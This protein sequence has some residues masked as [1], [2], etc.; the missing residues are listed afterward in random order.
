MSPNISSGITSF[1]FCVP[2]SQPITA[3][4]SNEIQRP[5]PPSFRVLG[6]GFN[7]TPTSPSPAPTNLSTLPTTL[8]YL[9]KSFLIS[10]ES[11]Q[12]ILTSH[13]LCTDVQTYY[14]SGLRSTVAHQCAS[15]IAS[16]RYLVN[17]RAPFVPMGQEGEWMFQRCMSLKVSDE[18]ETDYGSLAIAAFTKRRKTVRYVHHFKDLTTGVALGLGGR[19]MPPL[20]FDQLLANILACAKTNSD[21]QMGAMIQGLAMAL[22][23]NAMPPEVR[24]RLTEK[25]LASFAHCS[26]QQLRSMICGLCR[27]LRGVNMKPAHRDG[28]LEQLLQAGEASDE[29][30]AISLLDGLFNG[31]GV[32]KMNRAGLDAVLAKYVHFYTDLSSVNPCWEGINNLCILVGHCGMPPGM[33]D[34]ILGAILSTCKTSSTTQLGTM[35]GIMWRRL[36]GLLPDDSERTLNNLAGMIRQ[37]LNAHATLSPH[38]LG[39]LLCHMENALRDRDQI[40]QEIILTHQ[41]VLVKCILESGRVPETIAALQLTEHGQA[42]VDRLRP[43]RVN[44]TI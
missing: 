38:Q 7:K 23:G 36:G 1:S 10:K 33:R 21:R 44:T 13:R 31:M 15:P 32:W 19:L 29:L 22:G 17:R 5:Q 16:F 35:A 27:A 3:V 43:E 9:I 30:P 40:D 41:N 12:L 14:K 26:E 6:C 24:H 42:V 18:N 20:Y 2:A 4:S 37:I 39:S 11:L 28:L 8:L 25:I 34:A